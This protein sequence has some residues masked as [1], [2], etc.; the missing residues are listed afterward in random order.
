MTLRNGEGGFV[1]TKYDSTRG[2]RC[3][4]EVVGPFRV[5]V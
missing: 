2:G 1:E 5:G 4:K 3:S